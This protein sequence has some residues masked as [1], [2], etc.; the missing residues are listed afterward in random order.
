MWSRVAAFNRSCRV[1]PGSLL[2]VLPA[3]LS[4]PFV[5][6]LSRRVKTSMHGLGTVALAALVGMW[7]ERFVLVSPSLWRGD[8]VPL[9]IPEVLITGGMLSLF[10]ICYTTFL[11]TFPV[12]AVS[13]PRLLKD[14]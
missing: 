5:V 2:R 12:L 6:L 11:Q 10:G 7:V 4:V 13:D 8:G 14:A 3:V 9:G 1:P